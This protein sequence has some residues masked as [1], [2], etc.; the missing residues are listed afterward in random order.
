MTYVLKNLANTENLGNRKK[1][2]CFETQP[3]SLTYGQ[4]NSADSDF[5]RFLFTLFSTPCTVNSLFTGFRK[6][7]ASMKIIH[8]WECCGTMYWLTI[9]NSSSL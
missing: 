6:W 9:V 3:T 8:F 1:E 5:V 4:F 7:S 2:I